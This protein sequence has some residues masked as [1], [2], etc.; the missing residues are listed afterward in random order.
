QGD[1]ISTSILPNQLYQLLRPYIS[2]SEQSEKR[3]LATFS[4]PE[5]RAVDVDYSNTYSRVLSYMN[6]YTSISET[7]ALKLLTNELAIRRFDNLDEDTEEFKRTFESLLAEE[8]VALAE[9]A[10]KAEAEAR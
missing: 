3:F 7:T 1:E 10:T 9:T 4:I 5:F 8:N 6:T 2:F